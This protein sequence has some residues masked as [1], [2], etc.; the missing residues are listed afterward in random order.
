MKRFLKRYKTIIKAIA[1]VG[2]TV[3]AFMMAHEVATIQRGYEAIGGEAFI[4][5]IPFAIAVV[6]IVTEPFRKGDKDGLD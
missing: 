6:P 4:W 5:L 2:A 3:G 1:L